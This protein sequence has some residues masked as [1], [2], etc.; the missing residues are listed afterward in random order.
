M[1]LTGHTFRKGRIRITFEFCINP[2]FMFFLPDYFLTYK[3]VLF[4]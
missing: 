4:E 1:K 2:V 3:I